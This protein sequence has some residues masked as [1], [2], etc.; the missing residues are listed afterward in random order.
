MAPDACI[1]GRWG[2]RRG[3]TEVAEAGRP[4]GNGSEEEEGSSIFRIKERDL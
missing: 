1:W 3:K 4:G 2:K